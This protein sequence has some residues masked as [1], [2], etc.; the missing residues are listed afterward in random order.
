MNLPFEELNRCDDRMTHDHENSEPIRNS[1]IDSAMIPPLRKVMTSVYDDNAMRLRDA[2]TP[3]SATHLAAIQ[4]E[5][6][7]PAAE[8]LSSKYLCHMRSNEPGFS[9][10]HK[11]NSRPDFAQKHLFKSSLAHAPESDREVSERESDDAQSCHEA[12]LTDPVS[13]LHA[14]EGQLND[15]SATSYMPEDEDDIDFMFMACADWEQAAEDER[16][17]AAEAEYESDKSFDEATGKQLKRVSKN[18]RKLGEL[19]AASV[20]SNGSKAMG[21]CSSFAS[22]LASADNAT[23]SVDV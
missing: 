13:N 23:D 16:N 10:I 9:T 1:S 20:L 17:A 5:L 7:C 3:R 6:E 14:S 19:D 8:E 2:E 12:D 18:A 21:S 22:Y 4:E 15:G 11:T